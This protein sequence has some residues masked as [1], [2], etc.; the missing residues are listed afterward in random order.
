MPTIYKDQYYTLDPANPPGFGDA[1]TFTREEVVDFN[2]NGLI[3]PGDGDTFNGF[4]VTAVWQNDTVTINVPGVGNVTY[5]GATYYLDGGQPSVF[6][7]TDGQV[8]Q[9]GTF[10]TSGFVTSSTQ[11]TVGGFGPTCFTPGTMIETDNGPR[12]VE[13]LSEGDLIET[14]DDGIRPVRAILRGA[15]RAVGDLAPIRFATGAVGNDAPLMVSPQHRMLI[16]GW[17]AELLFGENE[18]LVA[19]KHM[20]NGDTITRVPGGLVTYIHLLFD[21][22]QIVFGQGVPSE[23]YFPGHAQDHADDP[24]LGQLLDLFPNVDRQGA[25]AWQTSRPVLR[26]AEAELLA[27]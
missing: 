18:V 16:S 22:H 9:N 13:D 17:R 1:V 12:P 6:T 24:V 2:D 8:L 25:L 26:R 4:E 21:Q 15:F 19:A 27:A 10:V 14:L 3:R 7:P 11:Q 23:S 20:V 5:V